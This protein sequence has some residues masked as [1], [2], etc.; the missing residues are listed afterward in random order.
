MKKI[1]LTGIALLALAAVLP[2]LA[3]AADEPAKG[4]KDTIFIGRVKVQPSVAA[5]ARDGGYELQVRRV[6]ESLET[7]FINA[8]NATRVFQLVD[9]KRVA[10]IQEEQA[11]GQVAVGQGAAQVLQMTGAKY[12]FLPEID[13]FEVRT[14]KDVYQTVGRESVTREYNLSVLVQVVNTTTGEV[15]PDSP[16]FQVTKVDTTG[17]AAP[18][19]AGARD[20]VLVEMAGEAAGR[21]SRDVV[22]LLRPAR[23]LKV[24]QL[25]EGKV[26]MLIN[27]GAQGG[28][29]PGGMVTVFHFEEVKDADTGEV[30]RD[31][32]PICRAKIVRG[33]AKQSTA[34]SIGEDLGV[35][36][37]C[38]VEL[39]PA[40]ASAVEIPRTTWSGGEEK[41]GTEV[42]PVKVSPDTPGSGAAP[43]KW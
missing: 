28:F 6:A 22:G 33:D 41:S 12:A 10:E 40:D 7:Q 25:G 4:G 29:E 36:E 23:V 27:R 13:G 39:D 5:L 17:M 1:F 19:Q 18:G 9:R 32:T 24:T 2:A 35:T 31:K 16:T 30:Y 34:L 38:I 43:L 26:Q 42:A 14:R 3:A 8:V 37:G 11:F 20:R 21:L 15:L